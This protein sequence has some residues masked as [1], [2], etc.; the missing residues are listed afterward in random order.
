MRDVDWR[1]SIAIRNHW[2]GQDT[3]GIKLCSLLADLDGLLKHLD[4]IG[5][6]PGNAIA[7]CEHC[8]EEHRWALIKELMCHALELRPENQ[9]KLLEEVDKNLDG[10]RQLYG[11][12]D[13]YEA[14]KRE[15]EAFFATLPPGN[16]YTP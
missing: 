12:K 3:G 6:K 10:V 9:S 7:H 8:G 16:R 13:G 14:M 4:E 5:L 15:A 2:R 1:M 11:G